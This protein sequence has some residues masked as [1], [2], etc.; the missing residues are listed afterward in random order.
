MDKLKELIINEGNVLENNFDA[1]ALC[2]CN[3]IRTKALKA[4]KET[5]FPDMK[6]EDWKYTNLNFLNSEFSFPDFNHFNTLTIP[7]EV[8]K[9]INSYSSGNN[10]LV[11]I[12][13]IFNKSLSNIILDSDVIKVS[14]LHQAYFNE[15]NNVEKYVIDDIDYKRFIFNAINTAVYK[16]GILL[17]IKC[18]KLI[19]DPIYIL[20]I[21]ISDDSTYFINPRNII[22]VGRNSIANII[23]INYSYGENANLVNSVTDLFVEEYSMI[24][25]TQLQTEKVKHNIIENVSTHLEKNA[26][27]NKTTITTEGKFIRNND[28]VIIADTDSEVNMNGLF[29]PTDQQYF[30]NH[31]F[32]IHKAERCR[33]N[34]NYKGIIDGK[35]KG[36]FN[37]MILVKPGAQQTNAY[38]SNK[39]ILLSDESVIYT[40]PELEIYADDVKCSHGATSGSINS[41]QLFYLK[42][43]GLDEKQAKALIVSGFAMEIINNIKFETIRKKME[44]MIFN[45][46]NVEI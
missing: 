46:L 1:R 40:K 16:D 32:I 37:G 11:L 15:P 36:V 29:F 5:G 19:E 18:N 25:Y 13:G 21:S 10:T 27:Y 9:F 24:N 43:R 26:V 44:Q 33:T 4:F 38:Q 35:G 28:Y 31:T 23:T 14:N 2:K 20:N 7:D 34:E 6:T 22:A 41:D 42:A 8:I 17:K 3:R 39:N 12:N 45:K 30:D